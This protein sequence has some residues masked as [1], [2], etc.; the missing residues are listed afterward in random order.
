VGVRFGGPI[1]VAVGDFNGDGV[2]D[3]AIG[4]YDAG[5]VSV[6][7]GS[8]YQKAVSV[9]LGATVRQIALADLDGD[10]NL[11]VVA[12][13]TDPNI[14]AVLKGKGDGTFERPARLDLSSRGLA[15]LAADLNGDGIPDLGIGQDQGML[16]AFGNGD[17]SFRSADP[18]FLGAEPVA[19]RSG[20]FNGDGFPDLAVAGVD[21]ANFGSGSVS[22][23]PG[24][25]DGGFAVGSRVT[26]G[27][28]SDLALGD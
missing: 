1:S 4:D 26:V 2:P 11:D 12:V 5:S 24:S 7:L 10:G 13:C 8:G 18:I 28:P 21:G 23:L 14:A 16:I 9:P 6:T 25:G 3:V 27:R 22:I 15:I 19:I 20:D 17:E